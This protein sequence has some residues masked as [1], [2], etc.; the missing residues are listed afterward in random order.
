MKFLVFNIFDFASFPWLKHFTLQQFL[1]KDFISLVFVSGFPKRCNV[2]IT[3][4]KFSIYFS[5][6][7]F[8]ITLSVSSTLYSLIPWKRRQLLH[9]C[10]GSYSE[11]HTWPCKLVIIFSFSFLTASN[12][13]SFPEI[14][15]TV[16]ARF[17]GCFRRF[18]VILDS[19]YFKQ[20][21]NISTYWRV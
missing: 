6:I 19:K 16:S 10:C 4:G 18:R 17:W 7:I 11:G 9:N 3:F 15:W 8:T 13:W 1:L 2:S 14:K 12:W 21:N 5:L 20:S